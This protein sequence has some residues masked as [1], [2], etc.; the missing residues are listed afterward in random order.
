[1]ISQDSTS[2][3]Q[4]TFWKINSKNLILKKFIHQEFFR[5]LQFFFFYLVHF[6]LPRVSLLCKR[7]NMLN[8]FVKISTEILKLDISWS[9]IWPGKKYLIIEVMLAKIWELFYSF[10]QAIHNF[11]IYYYHLESVLAANRYLPL[12]MYGSN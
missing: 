10:L 2:P 9:R 6:L 4:L 5:I 12:A 11:S 7:S 8:D 3:L 1:M